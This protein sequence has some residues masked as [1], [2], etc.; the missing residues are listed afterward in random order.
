MNKRITPNFKP[1]VVL[2]SVKSVLVAWLTEAHSR[3][4]QNQ[5]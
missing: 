2:N 4:P 1:R 5:R 3:P